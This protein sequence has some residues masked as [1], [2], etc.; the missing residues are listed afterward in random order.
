MINVKN[1]P[2]FVNSLK[3]RLF[4]S[5]L[6]MVV[7]MLPVIAFTLSNAFDSQL[8]QSMESEIKA[9]AY[10][11]LAITEVENAKLV[12]PNA[13]LENKFN[14]IQSGLYALIT[15]KKNN[16][17]SVNLDSSIDKHESILWRSKS[18]LVTSL[19]QE[20]PSP[21]IGT[22]SFT[23]IDI[24][25]KPHLL[26]SYSVSFSSLSQGKEQLFNIVLHVAK[27][28]SNFL[29]SLNSFKQA[30]WGW[31]IALMVLFVFIQS[32]WL[33]WTLKPLKSLQNELTNI[34][35]GIA[36]KVEKKYPV[37][38]Q[39]VTEQLNTLLSTEQS[40]RVRYRNALANLAHSL[41]NPLSVI[42]SQSNLDKSSSEQLLLINNIIEHQLKRAQS[43][44]ESSWH[45][46]VKIKP[47]VIKLIETLDKIYRDKSL[48][49]NVNIEESAMF[50]GDEADLLE[51][52]GNVLD[53]AYKAAVSNVSVE[54]NHCQSHHIKQLVFTI[55][56]DGS[57]VNEE[58][59][60]LILNRGTRSDTYQ[61]G[62][63]IGLAIVR[64][65]VESYQGT[66]CIS[67]SLLLGGAQFTLEFKA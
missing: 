12:M 30:L 64:D 43:A 26:F 46:G 34:E 45:L 7:I 56:D 42:Q 35:S 27:D 49:I 13:L 47:L 8:K 66:L 53:N 54:I 60:A 51:I 1:T 22:T 3:F 5:T 57:G 24:N 40:Q 67:D 50:K 14:V 11:I 62:H 20:L 52:L 29:I 33:L 36:N 44:G 10:S 37:E 6:L 2:I 4:L 9:Y 31:L 55:S 21:D 61:K 28:K 15:N 25:N 59:K 65:L 16:S 48:Q 41:K 17:K 63:G 18:L 32:L 58:N 39:H 19:E 38:L 23:D